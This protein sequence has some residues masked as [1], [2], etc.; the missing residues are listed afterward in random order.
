MQPSEEMVDLKVKVSKYMS[1]L[2][3]HNPEDS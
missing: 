3:R 1:Y 2:L